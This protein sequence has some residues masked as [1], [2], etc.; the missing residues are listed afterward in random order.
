[1]SKKIKLLIADDEKLLRER[2]YLLL[3]DFAPVE[4]VATA[5]N[6]LEALEKILAFAPQIVITDIVMPGMNGIELAE[7][8]MQ[9]HIQAQFIILSGHQD[10]QYARQAIRFGVVSYL[11]KPI[12]SEEL[13]AALNEAV[14]KLRPPSPETLHPGLVYSH[15]VEQLLAEVEN[16]LSNSRLSLKLIAQTRLFINETHAGRVFHRETGIKFSDYVNERR[17]KQA[18]ALMYGDPSLSILQLS[19]AVG[20]G[21]NYRYFIEIFKKHYNMTPKQFQL[22][23]KTKGIAN[24]HP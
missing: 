14:N 4:I 17:I 24:T 21:D 2:L 11:L 16:E 5:Q 19:E 22:S 6:G 23:L 3:R 8:C 18:V 13:F 15:T 12:S 10:F 20:F 7:R 9:Q 1:M